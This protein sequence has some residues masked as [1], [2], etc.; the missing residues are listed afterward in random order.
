MS[1]TRQTAEQ[2]A[3]NPGHSDLMCLDAL[4]SA[5]LFRNIIQLLPPLLFHRVCPDR[6]KQQQV[7]SLSNKQTLAMRRLIF[8]P[9]AN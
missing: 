1:L 3:V 6:L 7:L 5:E 2:H 9:C 8:E 4:T